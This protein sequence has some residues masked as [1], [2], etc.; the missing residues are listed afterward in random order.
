MRPAR[1]GD[2]AEIGRI[3]IETWRAAYAGF[4]PPAVLDAVDVAAASA[5]WVSALDAPPAEGRVLVASENDV[6]VGFASLQASDEETTGQVGVLLVEPRWGR[7]GHGSRLL[8][9]VVDTAR[10]AGLTRL[11]CWVP[12]RDLA[13][14]A[15]LTA[16]GWATDG[17]VRTLEDGATVVREVRMHT[18][19]G[20]SDA[21]AAP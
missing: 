2:A 16:A 7:R 19:I 21:A 20:S 11:V 6:L 8:A 5:Q 12:E 13:T 9:A 17:W 10:E 15:L 4:L 1:P 14:T 3:Q 18:D